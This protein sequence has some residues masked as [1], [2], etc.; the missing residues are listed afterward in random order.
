M[1]IRPQPLQPPWVTQDARAPA[2]YGPP[3]GCCPS[4]VSRARFEAVT[5]ARAPEPQKPQKPQKPQETQTAQKAPAWDREDWLRAQ[6]VG[7]IGLAG[8]NV[9]ECGARPGGPQPDCPTLIALGKPQLPNVAPCGHAPQVLA[10]RKQL[11]R[12]ELDPEPALTTAD[13]HRALEELGV[14]SFNRFKHE[15]KTTFDAKG[16]LNSDTLGLEAARSRLFKISDYITRVLNLNDEGNSPMTDVERKVSPAAYTFLTR[17]IAL[18]KKRSAQSSGLARPYFL[19][20]LDAAT[21]MCAEMT[22]IS[23]QRN[24]H[25]EGAWRKALLDAMRKLATKRNWGVDAQVHGSAVV[26]VILTS[27]FQDTHEFLRQLASYETP[28]ANRML[29]IRLA[30]EYVQIAN[31]LLGVYSV[32]VSELPNAM[33]LLRENHFLLVQAQERFDVYPAS[34]VVDKVTRDNY[35]DAKTLLDHASW[36]RA[37]EQQRQAVSRDLAPA[38]DLVYNWPN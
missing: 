28:K 10:S 5:R 38:R 16:P 30:L 36:M 25:D 26:D 21:L 13:L 15:N 35:A 14:P 18:S 19:A 7:T 2:P 20:L 23:K 3:L 24:A 22:D 37:Q 8:L 33:Q 29:D 4:K 6:P 34:S 12:A 27:V 17:L 1:S 11:A 32:L 31:D 9:S